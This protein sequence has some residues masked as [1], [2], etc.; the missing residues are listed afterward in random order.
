MPGHLPN[1]HRD[2]LIRLRKLVQAMHADNGRAVPLPEL[3]QLAEQVHSGSGVT[4]DFQAS[5]ELGGPMIEARAEP[6]L[7]Q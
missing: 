5:Q 6:D 3:M 2:S 1:L 4:V 7:G